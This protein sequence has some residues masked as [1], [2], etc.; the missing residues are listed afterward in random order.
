MSFPAKTFAKL[1]G[2]NPNEKQL[3]KMRNIF[4]DVCG[5]FVLAKLNQFKHFHNN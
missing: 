2:L 1:Q 4:K 5:C 3:S